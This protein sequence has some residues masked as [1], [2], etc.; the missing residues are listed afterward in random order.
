MSIERFKKFEQE[1]EDR[2]RNAAP[3]L[4]AALEL[5]GSQL[6]NHEYKLGGNN[7]YSRAINTAYN[8]IKLA[9]GE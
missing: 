1:K 7:E 8:A 3:Q 9:K 5:A 2:V 6:A 4:L